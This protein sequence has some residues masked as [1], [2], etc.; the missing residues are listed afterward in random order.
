MVLCD[1]ATIFLK[2]GYASTKFL[3]THSVLRKVKFRA[4]CQFVVTNDFAWVVSPGEMNS[5][6]EATSTAQTTETLAVS[7]ASTRGVSTS[8]ATSQTPVVHTTEGT[9]TQLLLYKL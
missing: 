2:F 8:A 7:T 6:T 3:Q 5:T 9:K 1:L 4:E